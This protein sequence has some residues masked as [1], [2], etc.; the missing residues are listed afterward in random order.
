M[1]M[2][3]VFTVLKDVLFICHIPPPPSFKN[4]H[5]SMRMRWALRIRIAASLGRPR[6]DPYLVDG[7]VVDGSVYVCAIAYA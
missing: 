6:R 3:Y 1:V 7:Y 4:L 2:Q 5:P